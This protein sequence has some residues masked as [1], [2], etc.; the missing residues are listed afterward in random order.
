M[1]KRT[2]KKRQ[3]VRIPN[4]VKIHELS[5]KLTYSTN[6]RENGGEPKGYYIFYV[7]E[8]KC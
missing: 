1:N 8:E 6:H 5:G 2:L 3:S 7:L 4:K